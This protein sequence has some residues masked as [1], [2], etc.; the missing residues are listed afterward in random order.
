MLFSDI[1]SRLRQLLGS[2]SFPGYI[3]THALL[4]D[5]RGIDASC[6][7][8]SRQDRSWAG[9]PAWRMA[10]AG[11]LLVRGAASRLPRAKAILTVLL[12][13]SIFAARHGCGVGWM[14]ISKRATCVHARGAARVEAPGRALLLRVFPRGKGSR[15]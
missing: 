4:L 8:R 10:S 14:I 12:L 13:G 1:F 7:A 3:D 2:A 6:R 5:A 15:Y 11:G 9:Q